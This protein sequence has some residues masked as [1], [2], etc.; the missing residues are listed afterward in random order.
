MSAHGLL[1]EEGR[2]KKIPLVD[3]IYKLCKNGIEDEQH[4]IMHCTALNIF[5]SNSLRIFQVFVCH[6]K[7]C[8]T[9]I[10]CNPFYAIKGMILML[11]A[12]LRHVACIVG[13]MCCQIQQCNTSY[14]PCL[15]VIHANNMSICNTARNCSPLVW[16][17]RVGFNGLRMKQTKTTAWVCLF[18]LQPREVAFLLF[19]AK[20]N[21]IITLCMYVWWQ[22]CFGILCQ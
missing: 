1:V 19:R 15:K 10:R 3:R 13:E 5:E 20:G 6:S 2:Y 22:S 11:F 16:N 8:Q 4:F 18:C 17:M 21:V 12:Y 7:T 9:L 14:L